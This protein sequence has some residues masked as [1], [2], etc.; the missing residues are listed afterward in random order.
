MNK[1][2]KILSILSLL[3]IIVFSCKKKIIEKNATN[4]YDKVDYGDTA[5]NTQTVLDPNS[6]EGIH[7]TILQPKCATPGCHDGHFEPDFRTIQSSYATM[8]WNRVKKNNASNSFKFRVVPYDYHNSWLHERLI[9]GDATLGRMPMYSSPLSS[10][11]MTQIKT[12]IENGAKDFLGNSPAYPNSEPTIQFY[13]LYNNLYNYR[14]D[15]IRVNGVSYN[16]MLLPPSVTTNNSTLNLVVSITDDSTD[17][18]ALSNNKVLFSLSEN[19]F[20]NPIRTLNGTYMNLGGS[21]VWKYTIIPAG[22]PNDTAIYMRVFTNDGD[23]PTDTQFP[24]NN[25]IHEYKTFFSFI[26]D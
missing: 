17:V 21:K 11:E 13:L 18:S 14:Y 16:S 6:I 7:K 3:T 23:H 12:W 24:T 1:L 22:L 19:D 10:A 5:T 26:L 15:T 9:T 2:Y 4:P 25:L 8:V 20:T